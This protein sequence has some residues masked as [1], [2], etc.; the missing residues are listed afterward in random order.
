MLILSEEIQ[1]QLK[2]SEEGSKF[3][4]I[5]FLNSFQDIDNWNF[6]I[7]SYSMI[8]NGSPLKYMSYHILSQ[9]GLIKKLRIPPRTLD[10]LLGHLE[11]GYAWYRTSWLEC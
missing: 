5:L 11:V 6:D 4:L 7:F 8:A 2:V 1:E 9:Y 10:I 3:L